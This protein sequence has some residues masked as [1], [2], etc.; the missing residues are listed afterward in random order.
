MIKSH[1]QPSNS[2][3]SVKD[4]DIFRWAHISTLFTRA[5]FSLIFILTYR[6]AHGTVEIAYFRGAFSET[7]TSIAIE[8]ET[9]NEAGTIGYYIERKISGSDEPAEIIS[10]KL[11][12]DGVITSFIPA[13]VDGATGH[14]YSVSD[15]SITEEEI[16]E[17]FLWKQELNSDPS[18]TGKA[19]EIEASPQQLSFEIDLPDDDEDIT[20][21]PSPTTGTGITTTITATTTTT[22]ATASSTVT[23]TATSTP[24]SEIS[25]TIMVDESTDN[26]E[27]EEVSETI[28]TEEFTPTTVSSENVSIEITPQPIQISITTRASSSG[29]AEAAELLQDDTY[30]EP[31]QESEENNQDYVPPATFAQNI[32]PIGEGVNSPQTQTEL[33]SQ[34]IEQESQGEISKSRIILWGGFLGSLLFF[35]SVV[36]GTILMYRQRYPSNPNSG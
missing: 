9:A 12:P 22:S 18:Q 5:V 26:S 10:V 32:Q 13:V 11:L 3:N 27:D 36:I 6:V 30:P 23:S 16:Y 7:P 31:S 34:I 15:L 25:P 24:T 33:G 29:A 14:R 8:W 1:H 21:S 20:A 2:A 28:P 4:N 35:V 19:F 17:Y